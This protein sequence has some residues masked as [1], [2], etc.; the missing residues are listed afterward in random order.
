MFKVGQQII[1]LSNY[2]GAKPGLGIFKRYSTHNDLWYKS[3][4]NDWEYIV[5]QDL[6]IPC[7][8]YN[9]IFKD[10]LDSPSVL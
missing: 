5:H 4:V 1:I 7:L 3:C 2:E 9:D 6:V 8:E 10:L